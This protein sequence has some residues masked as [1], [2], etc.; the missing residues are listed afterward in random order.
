MKKTI[1]KLSALFLL[2]GILLLGGCSAES[3]SASDP[4]TGFEVGEMGVSDSGEKALA[5]YGKLLKDNSDVDMTTVSRDSDGKPTQSEVLSALQRKAKLSFVNPLTEEQMAETVE[6][7]AETAHSQLSKESLEEIVKHQ[8]NVAT[9]SDPERDK[10][11]Q[12]SLDCQ[13]KAAPGST[14]QF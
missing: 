12:L 1:S 10:F 7:T 14:T 3:E 4:V 13:E 5:E 6:C 2:G 8:R 11:T 9:L